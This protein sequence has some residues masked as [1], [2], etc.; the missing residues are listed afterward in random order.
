MSKQKYIYYDYLMKI[1]GFIDSSEEISKSK[2][3][4]DKKN[5]YLNYQKP[6]EENEY[7]EEEENEEI[8]QQVNKNINEIKIKNINIIDEN[9]NKKILYENKNKFKGKEKETLLE[10]I[11]EKDKIITKLKEEI[12]SQKNQ[13]DKLKN[14]TRIINDLKKKN[15][16]ANKKIEQ[17]KEEL[18]ITQK[19]IEDI[20]KNSILEN[21][22]NNN[23]DEKLKMNVE[24]ANINIKNNSNIKRNIK[25]NKIFNE[26]E[27]NALL[28]LFKTEEDLNNFN[29]KINIVEEKTAKNEKELLEQ[30]K[31]L[32][33]ELK[34]NQEKIKN[35]EKKLEEKEIEKKNHN[36]NKHNN[37][38]IN[39]NTNK[40]ENEAIKELKEKD[41]T[42]DLLKKEINSLKQAKISKNLS[43]S[44]YNK[45][46]ILQIK[47]QTHFFYIAGQIFNS[48]SFSDYG[49]NQQ[50]MLKKISDE[51]K[52]KVIR[53][54]KIKSNN[55]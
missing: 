1:N 7:E 38:N 15:E 44:H 24:T 11:K 19:K 18:I 34:E 39:N 26:E 35:L 41:N 31:K 20:N 52:K 48:G 16:E 51:E 22:I 6:I 53:L 27:K 8:Q 10:L 5:N 25:F 32:N 55:K 17:L 30:N 21:K 42:I 50:K 45:F 40:N 2:V 36:N 33:K 14:N 29:N 4:I 43:S 49:P 54:R 9:K 3:T 23:K 28:I 13:I 37:Y 12:E 46:N 47:R